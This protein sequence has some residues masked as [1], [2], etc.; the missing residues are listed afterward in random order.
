VTRGIISTEEQAVQ[1]QSISTG[2]LLDLRILQTDASINDGDS[3]GPLLNTRGEVIGIITFSA[4]VMLFD[5]SALAEGIGHSI[6]SNAVQPVLYDLANRLRPAIGI[7]GRDLSAARAEALGIPVIGADVDRVMAG[8]A[9]DQAGIRAG[10]VIT[11]F[12]D[13]PVLDMDQLRA[14]IAQ[15]RPGDVVEV[16]I[17]RDGEA[18]ILEVKLL[19]MEFDTF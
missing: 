13:R 15:L 18:M 5:D 4:T 9:A 14:E 12:N 10:D 17:L 19:P 16:R 8:G 11:G 7:V 2:R 1:V 3:G 6:S